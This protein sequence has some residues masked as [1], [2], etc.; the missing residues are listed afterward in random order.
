MNKG[1]RQGVLQSTDRMKW[2]SEADGGWARRH[3]SVKA[4]ST[5]W[6]APVALCRRGQREKEKEG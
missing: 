3:G 5:V 4:H 1:R 2:L 6:A